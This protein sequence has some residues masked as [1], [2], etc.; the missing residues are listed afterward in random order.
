VVTTFK[1]YHGMHGGNFLGIAGTRTRVSFGEQ[2]VRGN[3]MS[4]SHR[5]PWLRPPRPARPQRQGFA[6]DGGARPDAP[7]GERQGY[8]KSCTLRSQ[9]APRWWVSGCVHKLGP[10]CPCSGPF[11]STRSTAP[12]ASHPCACSRLVTV[13][14][15]LE[16]GECCTSPVNGVS[17]FQDAMN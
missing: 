3:A 1:T 2:L 13:C 11:S 4:A 12:P 16:S 14:N 9:P 17:G 10:G 5:G 15:S 6:D 8:G 7:P